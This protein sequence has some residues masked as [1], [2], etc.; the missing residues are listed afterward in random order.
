MTAEEYAMIATLAQNEGFSVAQ[1][2]RTLC[3]QHFKSE[4][5]S[6]KEVLEA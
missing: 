5:V 1:M 3:R 6:P 4:Q 2:F